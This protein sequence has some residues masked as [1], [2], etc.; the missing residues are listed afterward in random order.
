MRHNNAPDSIV[1]KD[2][3]IEYYNNISASIDDD[4]YYTVMMTNAW[5]LDG[6]RAAATAKNKSGGKNNLVTVTSGTGNTTGT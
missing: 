1:T 5:D 6:V 4:E 2:E 3:F